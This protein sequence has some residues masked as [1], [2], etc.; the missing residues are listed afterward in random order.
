MTYH[1]SALVPT[2]PYMQNKCFV[3]VKINTIHM[4]AWNIIS[5]EYKFS[6]MLMDK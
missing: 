4:R 2:L 6:K 5:K 1:N 3:Q